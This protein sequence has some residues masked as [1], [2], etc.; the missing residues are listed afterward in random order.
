MVPLTGNVQNR[1]VHRQKVDWSLLEAGGTE[2]GDRMLMGLG[3]PFG[4]LEM[5]KTRLW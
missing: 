4:G 5:S 1:P 2:N 3:S